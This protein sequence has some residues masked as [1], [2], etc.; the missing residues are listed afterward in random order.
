MSYSYSKAVWLDQSVF[1]N[2]IFFII[3]DLFTCHLWPILRL[4]HN[5]P[6][7]YLKYL[8]KLTSNLTLKQPALTLDHKSQWSILK[9]PAL[10]LDHKSQWSILKQPALSLDHTSQWSKSGKLSRKNWC[11]FYQLILNN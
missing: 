5:F 11:E 8:N 9:H 2:R 10:T 4:R 1:K 7:K 6:E 3:L